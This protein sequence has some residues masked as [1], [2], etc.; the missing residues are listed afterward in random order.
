[1]PPRSSSR[2]SVPCLRRIVEVVSWVI[3]SA[4]AMDL[5]VRT[6]LAEN[7]LRYLATHPIDILTVVLP[8]L[9]PL[10]VLRVFT[11]GQALIGRAGQFS[12]VHATRA[13]SITAGLLVFIAAL[14][15]LDAERSS[16]EANIDDFPDALWWA[17]TT[18]TTVG[19]GDRYPVTGTGRVV[20]A[21][22][23][24]L[25]IALVGAIT[26]AVAGWFVS[27]TQRAVVAEEHAIEQRLRLIEERLGEL[28]GNE[29]GRK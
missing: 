8:A 21:A 12:F 25:G 13:I 23:M 19:Y 15:V 2:T 29:P 26:A 14:A 28:P 24:L 27:Q 20:A 11:A 9:R 6:A 16:P 22:L 4:F 18:V 5:L 17:A 3:W 7:R 1:M 10:R